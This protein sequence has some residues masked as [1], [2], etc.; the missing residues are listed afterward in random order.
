MAKQCEVCEKSSQKGHKVS[1]SNRK[2]RKF[3][4]PNLQQV[5]LPIDGIAKKINL[6]TNCLKTY[7]KKGV[8]KQEA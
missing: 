1:H 6:C 3:W 8:I 2:S 5:K 7:V 4:K